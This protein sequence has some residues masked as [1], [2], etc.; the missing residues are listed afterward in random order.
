MAEIRASFFLECEELIESL[1]DALLILESGES[2][3]EIINVVFRA[4]H[5]IKGGA[6]AFGLTALVNFAH[7]FETVLDELR[8]DRLELTAE[9]VKLFFQGAD[10]LQ[11]HIKAA[12]VEG[13]E[14]DCSDVVLAN[15]EAL[16]GDAPPVEEEI[17][18]FSPPASPSTSAI[19]EVVM[20]ATTPT[21]W[22]TALMPGGSNFAPT[23]ASFVAETR[24]CTS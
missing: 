21:C 7:R 24:H 19:L 20:T 2:D 9:A 23:P 4:V 17:V 8:S 18:D 16:M 22:K 1:Q 6:G 13:P 11:D 3:T 10:V 14:P 12:Q 15:L 5:S